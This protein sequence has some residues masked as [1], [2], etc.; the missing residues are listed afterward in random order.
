MCS[1]LVCGFVVCVCGNQSQ[2]QVSSLLREGLLLNL[3][4]IS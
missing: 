2:H 1:D 3:E 4:L